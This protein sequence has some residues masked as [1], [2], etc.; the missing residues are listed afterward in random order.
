MSELDD[1]MKEHIAYIVFQEHRPFSYRDFLHFEVEGKEYGMA[2]GTFRN[3][4]SRLI[5]VGEVEISYNSCLVFYT[6]KGTKFGKSMTSNHMGVSHNPI[7]KLIQNLPF[8]K[9]ALHDIHLRFQVKGCWSLLS[10]SSTCRM[11]AISKDI[12]LPPLKVGNL[13]IRMTVHRTDTVSVVV[14]CSYSPI[15][16]DIPGIIRL[17]NALTRVEERLSRL[18]E[19][20]CGNIIVPSP[21]PPP[22]QY[23][24]KISA[25]VIPDYRSW[26]VTMWHF[27]ADSSIDYSG[28]KFSAS[29]EI[30]E[31]KLTATSTDKREGANLRLLLRNP[32]HNHRAIH[33]SGGQSRFKYWFK[34][35][36]SN[37][38]SIESY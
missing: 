10:A 37:T 3:K 20:H 26:L 33:G 23:Q 1:A 36:R 15:A 25:A 9:N 5:K 31:H 4:I 12:Y 28:E 18:I 22:G 24:G 27:G 19:E 7:V 32:H 29:W 21:P 30:G 35:N 14:G 17:S 6:L 13:R 2:H 16:V 34:S 8:D 38:S 11:H